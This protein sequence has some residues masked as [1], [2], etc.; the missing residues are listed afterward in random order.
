MSTTEHQDPVPQSAA[1]DHHHLDRG[2][3]EKPPERVS[4]A[5]L[6]LALVA[7]VLVVLDISVVNTALPTIGADL[8]LGQHLRRVRPGSGAPSRIRRPRRKAQTGEHLIQDELRV[9]VDH[10]RRRQ[11]LTEEPQ[12]GG[13]RDSGTPHARDPAHDAVINDDTIHDVDRNAG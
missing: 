13:D 1:N 5:V 4:W 12:D 7:Q 11:T 6:A 3:H 9:V 10:L 8:Q 2:G